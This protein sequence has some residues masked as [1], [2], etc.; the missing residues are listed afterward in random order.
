MHQSKKPRTLTQSFNTQV[1]KRPWNFK[2][3]EQRTWN[4]NT[5]FQLTKTKSLNT[6][7]QRTK[8]KNLVPQHKISTHLTK[9]LGASMH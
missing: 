6:K 4:L 1:D 2:A 3:L 7:L 8:T 5:K 9:N